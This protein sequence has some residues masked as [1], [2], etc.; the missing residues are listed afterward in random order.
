MD[1]D[2][3]V[4]HSVQLTGVVLGFGIRLAMIDDD[5]RSLLSIT[6]WISVDDLLNDTCIYFGY[7][8]SRNLET[9]VMYTS[10]PQPIFFGRYLQLVRSCGNQRRKMTILLL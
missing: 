5:K 3:G 1:S 7:F 10:S 2:A 6:S 4:T 8:D 9:R